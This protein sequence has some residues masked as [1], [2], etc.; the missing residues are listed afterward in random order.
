MKIGKMEG[1]PEEIKN[2]FQDNGL[3]IPDFLEKPEA[4]LKPIWLIAPVFL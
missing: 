2:F 4:P 3:N 1:S